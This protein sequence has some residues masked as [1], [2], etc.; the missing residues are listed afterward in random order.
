M[1]R[2]FLAGLLTGGLIVGGLA[3]ALAP[4]DAAPPSPAA[5]PSPK[6]AERPAPETRPGAASP[7]LPG[8]LADKEARIA[9]LEA[10]VRRLGIEGAFQRGRIRSHEGTPQ[11]WPEE[12]PESLRPEAFQRNLEA[13]LADVDGAELLGVDCDEY[14]CVAFVQSHHPGGPD[15]WIAS[16]EP[17]APGVVADLE[18]AELY[19]HNFGEDPKVQAIAVYAEESD[20]VD[21]RTEF[22]VE[23]TIG[24]LQDEL[25]AG[26]D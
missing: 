14:P 3:L 4:P 13:A 22:R 21:Q 1:N 23:A 24:D 11:D 26:D 19:I 12:L 25:Q 7:A 5:T 20:E 9:E 18:G 8:E 17:L 2:S 15:E 16:L 6:Q 10:Q